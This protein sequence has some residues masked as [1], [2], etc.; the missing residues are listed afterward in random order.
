MFDVRERDGACAIGAKL[1]LRL[2]ARALCREVR[3][4]YSYCAAN[5]H[6]IHVG[7]GQA[8]AAEDVRVRWA[9]EVVESFGTIAAGR[10]VTIRRGD[11]R[12]V[13]TQQGVPAS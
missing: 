7:L 5:D 13:R 1:T 3:T 12:I 8:S 10:I 11:G 4:A 2:G 6:R 9:D